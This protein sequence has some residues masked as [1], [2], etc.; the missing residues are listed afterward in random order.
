MLIL[1]TAPPVSYELC[2]QTVTI[3]HT[4]GKTYTRMFGMMLFWISKR[5]KP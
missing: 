2:N 4:D 3:Y 5:W 1:P